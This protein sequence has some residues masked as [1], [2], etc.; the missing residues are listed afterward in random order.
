MN[1]DPTVPEAGTY[2]VDFRDGSV[3]Q[4][5]GCEGGL[6][7]LRPLGGGREWHCPPESLGEAPP[8]EVLRERVRRLNR[9]RRL[10]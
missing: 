7:H 6:V 2:A 8:G 10:P 3:G 5:M 4:V 1:G 9:E